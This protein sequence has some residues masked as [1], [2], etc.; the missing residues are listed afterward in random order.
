MNRRCIL[1]LPLFF[2][3]GLYLAHREYLI[4]FEHKPLSFNV[5][6]FLNLF[7]LIS[8]IS[9][10]FK[11]V[12]ITD[13]SKNPFLRFV[14]AFLGMAFGYLMLKMIVKMAYLRET[15]FGNFHESK[16]HLITFSALVFA[17]LSCFLMPKAL[18]LGK[19]KHFSN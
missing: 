7:L 14:F 10:F 3:V 17:L 19:F 2:G 9:P 12:G 18:T 15:T 4:V 16:V 8:W 13:R 6:N 1:F 5:L 11:L